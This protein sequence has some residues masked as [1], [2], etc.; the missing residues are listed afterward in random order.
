MVYRKKN[1]T[2]IAKHLRTKQFIHL[3]RIST[4]DTT[5]SVIGITVFLLS[6]RLAD[7]SYGRVG[8]WSQ[9]QHELT[10]IYTVKKVNLIIPARESLVTNIPAEDGKIANLLLQCMK[11]RRDLIPPCVMHMWYFNILCKF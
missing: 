4:E 10:R 8:R 1:I 3:T 9:R 7:I 5:F 11:F 6:A 2:L